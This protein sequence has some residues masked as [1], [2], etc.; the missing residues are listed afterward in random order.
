MQVDQNDFHSLLHSADLVEAN[1]RQQLAPLGIQPRQARVLDAMDRL[2]PISQRDL[3][4]EFG[5]T[6]ASMSTMA[7]RLRSAGY[8]TRLV[9][10]ASRRQHVL[11]LT[12][13]GRSLLAGIEQ[14]WSEVDQTLRAI[15]GEDSKAFFDLS[16]RLR[17]GMGGA[18]PGAKTSRAKAGRAASKADLPPPLIGK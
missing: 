8:I 17:D 18:A 13:K 6:P 2:G 15:L 1:L 4:A 3:A 9:D 5:I 12:D 10:P 7:D 14:A 16:R 11:E